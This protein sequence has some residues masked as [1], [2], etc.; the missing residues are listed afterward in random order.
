VIGWEGTRAVSIRDI[1]EAVRSELGE[2]RGPPGPQ[3]PPGVVIGQQSIVNPF[4]Y[5]QESPAATW[6][7][8]HDLNRYPAAV[9][10]V[11]T[12]GTQMWG[13]VDYS[14]P[15]RIT[16]KFSAPFAGKAYLL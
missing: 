6:V 10:V 4:V 16:V 7:I 14:F 11:D 9:S 2:M 15:E 3:G 12:A 8:D 1:V 13:E 5:S